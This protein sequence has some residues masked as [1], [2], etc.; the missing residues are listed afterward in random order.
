MSLPKTKTIVKHLDLSPCKM[1]RTVAH[2]WL[3]S[4]LA[5]L[6]V[7]DHVIFNHE[8]I[9]RKGSLQ[10]KY[11]VPPKCYMVSVGLGM[12]VFSNTVLTTPPLPIPVSNDWRKKREINPK[13]LYGRYGYTSA[14]KSAT[15]SE[16]MLMIRKGACIWHGASGDFW[17]QTSPLSAPLDPFSTTF[18]FRTKLGLVCL[19]VVR[20]W[21]HSP[22]SKITKNLK[23]GSSE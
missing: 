19:L 12:T 11:P 23:F 13:P 4:T 22:N 5:S 10:Q 17:R 9:S 18:E 8:F 6:P 21:Q 16:H 15:V 1:G 20:Q 14:R 7:Y 3:G 2:C